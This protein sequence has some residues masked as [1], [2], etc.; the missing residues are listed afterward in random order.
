MKKHR[1]TVRRIEF[2]ATHLELDVVIFNG[3]LTQTVMTLSVEPEFRLEDVVL[4]DRIEFVLNDKDQIK[5][6]EIITY[7]YPNLIELKNKFNELHMS[8]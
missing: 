2:T 4:F 7:Q 5:T 1:G 8:A 6:I 3:E